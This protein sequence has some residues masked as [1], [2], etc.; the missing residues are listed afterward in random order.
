[1]PPQHIDPLADLSID[2]KLAALPKADIH[3]HQEWSPRLDRVLAKRERRPPYAWRTWAEQLQAEVPPGA[4]RLQRL[5]TIFPATTAAD[6]SEENVIARFEDLVDEAAA[7]GAVLVELRIGNDTI[8]RPG[9]MALIREA[10]RRVRQQYPRV[11]VAVVH[12]MLLWI[13][14]ARVQQ[15]MEACIAA[16]REGLGGIDLLYAP[17]DSEAD[18]K[19][20]YRVAERAAEAGLGITA[21]AGEFSSANIAAAAHVPGLSRLGH[22]VYAGNDPRLLEMLA[23]AKIT[24]ECA[25][26]CNVVLGAA[27]SYEQ[28]PIRQFVASGIPVALCTDD[29]VQLS[30]TIGREYA[31]AAALGFASAELLSFSANAIHASFA[32]LERKQEMLGVLRE[33]EHM[34]TTATGRPVLTAK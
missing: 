15:Q 23:D 3:V 7:D 16:A 14:P 1:M 20:I 32:P 18:W 31:I 17:Y 29:P 30:T 11:H 33:W 21:H 27:P 25:L 13:D 9:I 12:T 24:V 22:A 26:T 10:E 5:S 28:H 34:S 6:A 19:P 8:L 2:P 4:G